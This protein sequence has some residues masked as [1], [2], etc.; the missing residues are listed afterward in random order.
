MNVLLC[1]AFELLFELFDVFEDFE[2]LL[3][4][5]V[6]GTGLAGKNMFRGLPD[7][8]LLYGGTA[9]GA[10]LGGGAAL[11]GVEGGGALEA[12]MFL[13][14]APS[15]FLGTLT[16]FLVIRRRITSDSRSGEAAADL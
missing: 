8:A 5:F 13:E 12:T 16:G 3:D 2:G 11:G 15:P 6:G 1:T 4:V 10:G 7:I 9:L 14:A